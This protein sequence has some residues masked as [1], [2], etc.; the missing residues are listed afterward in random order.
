M[1]FDWA[2]KDDLRDFAKKDDLQ[3]FATK[4]E[5]K[6]VEIKLETKLDKL[7]DKVDD[8]T[9]GIKELGW[10]LGSIERLLYAVLVAILAGLAKM[11]FFSN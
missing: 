10:R 3:K 9:L 4:S 7:K 6:E 5:L 2:T 1:L 8:N 11:F